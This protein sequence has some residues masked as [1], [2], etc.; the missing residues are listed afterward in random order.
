MTITE[1]L[2]TINQNKINNPQS[3]P[4]YP[5]VGVLEDGS[6]LENAE[7]GGTYKETGLKWDF[8]SPLEAQV[9]EVQEY[10]TKLL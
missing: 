7:T 3:T 9:S 10:F 4:P 5:I 2:K 6:I 1:V 8:E